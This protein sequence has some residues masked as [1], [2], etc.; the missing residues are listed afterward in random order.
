M[1]T[2]INTCQTGL[3]KLKT[4]TWQSTI[5]QNRGLMGELHGIQSVKTEC[6]S[7]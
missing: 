2:L 7:S 1:N 4:D 6:I 5:I 3:E